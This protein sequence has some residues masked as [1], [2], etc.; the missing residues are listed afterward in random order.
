MSRS[1]VAA[2]TAGSLALTLAGCG[3]SDASRSGD[4]SSGGGGTIAFATVSP[5]IP[6]LAQLGDAVTEYMKKQGVDVVVQ[7]A[8]FDPAKQAQQLTTAINNGQIK[9]GWVFPVAAAALKPVIELAQAK[10]VPLVVEAGPSDLGY[11]GP[12][13]GVVFDA[14]SFADYG[15]KIAEEAA[16]CV[17]SHGGEAKV[18]FLETTGVAAGSKAVHDAI[19]STFAEDASGATIVAIAQAADLQSAQTKMTELL[20]ANPD[21]T[22]V[23]AGSDETA[24]GALGALAA[25]GKTADCVIDGGGGPDALQALKD[26]KL[27]AIVAWDNTA[28]VQSA[29]ASLVK[30][31]SDPTAEGGVFPTPIKVLR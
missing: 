26:G 27:T 10:Q 13:P 2:A 3:S 17:N 21:I 24:L 11:D 18:A 30:L 23:I 20:L 6:V 16:S 8:N 15:T 31:M 12:Q 22:A 1:L 5:R 4:P 28:G 25:A 29:G 14:A 19:T 7:D 9:A